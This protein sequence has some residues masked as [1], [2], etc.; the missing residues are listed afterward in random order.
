MCSVL[1]HGSMHGILILITHAL[2]PLISVQPDVTT[3]LWSEHSLCMWA[4]FG[5]CA[6]AKLYAQLIW[7]F[8]ARSDVYRNLVYWSRSCNW[9]YLPKGPAPSLCTW[10]SFSRPKPGGPIACDTPPV[11]GTFITVLQKTKYVSIYDPQEQM[12][13]V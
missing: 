10:M 8:T 11:T 5:D 4:A 7:A 12:F 3:N 2:M 1:N 13:L 6:Y 9:Q